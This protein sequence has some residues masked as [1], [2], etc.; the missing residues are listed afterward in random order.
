MQKRT[1][2]RC[3]TPFYIYK[4]DGAKIRYYSQPVMKL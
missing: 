4:I 1:F 3:T 2:N